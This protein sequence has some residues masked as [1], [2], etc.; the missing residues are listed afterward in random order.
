VSLF[1]DIFCPFRV[2]LQVS[3][4][5]RGV[6]RSNSKRVTASVVEVV[7]MV[8]ARQRTYRASL[9]DLSTHK[10]WYLGN[11]PG[12]RASSMGSW[13]IS[14][15]SFPV[16]PAL[17]RGADTQRTWSFIVTLD[18]GI[19]QDCCKA[20][21]RENLPSVSAGDIACMPGERVLAAFFWPE[22]ILKRPPLQPQ[23]FATVM[24]RRM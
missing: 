12:K 5:G 24:R 22:G 9:A 18:V 2:G 8:E 21:G 20:L 19:R 7:L 13:S 23:M 17:H 16:V 15:W 6:T 14:P 1:A 4:T 10:S 3:L 11:M